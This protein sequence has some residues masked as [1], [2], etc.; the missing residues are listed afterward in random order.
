MIFFNQHKGITFLLLASVICLWGGIFYRIYAVAEKE[1]PLVQRQLQKA[2]YFNL[3][4]HTNDTLRLNFNY[5][6]PFANS[7]N[8]ILPVTPGG[9]GNGLIEVSAVP[10]PVVNWAEVNYRGYITNKNTG[11]RLAIVLIN[12]EE[13]LLAEGQTLN[14]LSLLKQASDSIKVK[15]RNSV[16][17][18]KIK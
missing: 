5:S 6:D 16:R 12:E 3:V 17:F 7:W 8:A 10:K 15:Y 18:I 13:M 1:K 9:Q 14:G 11:K 2:A 4:N